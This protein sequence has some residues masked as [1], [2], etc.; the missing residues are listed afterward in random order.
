[1]IRWEEMESFFQENDQVG[2]NG[3]LLP[4]E[5]SGGKRWS[6]STKRM[7]RLAEMES[8]SKKTIRWAEMKSPCKG[9]IRWA[10]ME[11]FFQGNVLVGRDQVPLPGKR[12]GGLRWSPSSRIMIR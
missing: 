8:L 5:L 11:P 10:K 3:V 6:P 1:M 4:R 7:I 12:S 9:M 2:R